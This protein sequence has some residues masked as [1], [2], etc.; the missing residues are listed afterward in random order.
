MPDEWNSD[1]ELFAL[2]GREL[3]TP[4]VGDVLDALGRCHQFL[5]QPVQPLRG[6]F[7]GVGPG[8]LHHAGDQGL[9]AG[10]ALDPCTGG[11]PQR[12]QQRRQRERERGVALGQ[13]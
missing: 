2:A 4:V 3:Y 6:R 13:R 12:L 11:E 9:E 7:R 1:A 5:P 10:Q 8:L